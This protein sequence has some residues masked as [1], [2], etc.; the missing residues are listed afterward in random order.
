[1]AYRDAGRVERAIA[2]FE[3]LLAAR[4][5]ILGADHPDTLAARHNLAG[6]DLGRRARGGGDR[7][8]RAAAR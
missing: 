7:D 4:E 8:L 5:R 6:A 2:I 3:S 1:V